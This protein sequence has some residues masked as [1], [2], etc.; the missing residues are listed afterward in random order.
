MTIKT[1]S[2]SS[3]GTRSK[4][5]FSF[6]TPRRV[7]IKTSA[8]ITFFGDAAGGVGFPWTADDGEFAPDMKGSDN[9]WVVGE[10]TLYIMEW[11]V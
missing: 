3:T 2:H 11:S 6:R 1:T 4:V 10:A 5:P 8:D 9:L 7:A